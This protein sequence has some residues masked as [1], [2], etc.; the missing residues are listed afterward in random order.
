MT[1]SRVFCDIGKTIRKINRWLIASKAIALFT[2]MLY[3]YYVL[4]KNPTKEEP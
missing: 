2:K 3:Y 4:I 1:I